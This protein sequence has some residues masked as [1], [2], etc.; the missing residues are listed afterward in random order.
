MRCA[1]ARI[2]GAALS[3]R[4]M[5]STSPSPS[6]AGSSSMNEAATG[7]RVSAMP[8]LHAQR[9]PTR[10]EAHAPILGGDERRP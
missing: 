10:R 3:S 5:T 7:P 1:L 2:I 4:E 8:R 6:G 9:H